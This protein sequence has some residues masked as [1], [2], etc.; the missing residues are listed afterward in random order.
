VK[1]FAFPS[2]DFDQAVAALC[3]GTVSDEQV[4]ALNELLASDAA[5]RDEYI[6]RL[7]LHSRLASEPDILAPAELPSRETDPPAFQIDLR[8]GNIRSGS[9]GVALNKR[10]GRIIAVAACLALLAAGGW[11]LRPAF[12][13]GRPGAASRAV[14]I[15]NRVVDARWS[16]PDP[17]PRLGAPL[18]PGLL[19]L[20][21]GL[22]Q[23]VFYNGARVAVEGPAELRLL[24]SSE[25]A[26]TEGKLTAEVPL[27]AHGFRVVAP[28]MDVTD[29]GT[30]FGLNIGRSRTELHVFKGS[31]EF[32]ANQASGVQNLKEGHG[33][34]VEG[35]SAPKLVEADP[36]EF[37]S[38]FDLQTRS[39]AAEAQRYDQWRA[40]NRRLNRD[41]SLWVHF[42]FEHSSASD[43]QLPNIG[44]RSA[45]APDAT[46]IG[47]H[48]SEG[49]WNMKPALEFRGVGDRVRMNLPDAAQAITLSAWV[50]VQG[51]D[52]QINSLFMS[53]GFLPGTLHWTIRKD[54]VQGLTVIGRGDHQIL[55][56][57]PVFTVDQ[58][59]LW[60]HVAVVVN[61]KARRVTHY[62]N[63]RPVS[64]HSIRIG[65]PFRIGSA[66]LGNW[67]AVGFA[68]NDPNLLRNFS[69]VVD[70][71]C[72]FGRAL[73]SDEVRTLYL[74]GKPQ[75]DPA[76]TA[77]P[78]TP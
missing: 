3:H 5:A 42:D 32:R 43:W 75:A 53:D 13:G 41:P 51:L 46:I 2:H 59:G 45:T 6:I 37:A 55:V 18:E 48:W 19:R 74:E 34:T 73:S 47:A 15:L 69:G 56:S 44:A 25:A 26:L 40:V 1:R 58:F 4:G 8:A 71:F 54:G 20:K 66:E 67:N 50:R 14:A 30:S 31:V 49:R 24:S 28:R 16:G 22:V 11:W 35:T 78:I 61:G 65:P 77:N 68:E 76:Q 64:Q 39:L 9:G 52:R 10:Y 72:L 60:T 62:V 33:A 70:E 29:L 12:T 57:P 17:A 7:E 21:S 63:G 23:I 27:Q 38:L 36:A